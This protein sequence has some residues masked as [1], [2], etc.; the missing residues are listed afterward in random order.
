MSMNDNGGRG[1]S[2]CDR[3]PEQRRGR[4]DLVKSV[5]G[6]LLRWLLAPAAFTVVVLHRG[7]RSQTRTGNGEKI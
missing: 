3:G 6:W 5:T 2:L 1:R 4:R 7:P